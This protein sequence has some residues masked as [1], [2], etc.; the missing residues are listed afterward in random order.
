VPR[1]L[2]L[3]KE[4]EIRALQDRCRELE[5]SNTSLQE[6]K[7]QLLRDR[8]LGSPEIGA[9]TVRIQRNSSLKK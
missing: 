4:R 8:E 1:M 2:L 6:E 5:N 7:E 3:E 9:Y